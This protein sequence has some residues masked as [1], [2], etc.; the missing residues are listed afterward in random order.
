MAKKYTKAEW[1]KTNGFNAAG[2]T[3]L[4]IGYSYSIRDELKKAGF[5]FSPLLR[6]HCG[7]DRLAL[8]KSCSY[9]ELHFD[10]YFIWDEN[11]GASFMREGARDKIE[12]IF[13]PVVETRSQYVGEIGD[14]LRLVPMRTS[15]I[16]GYECEY[17]YKW[18]YTFEDDNGNF[19]SWSTTSQHP[20]SV[21]MNCFVTGT[22]KDHLNYKNIPTT[23]L[24]RCHIKV[25]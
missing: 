23:Q 14:R 21:G 9:H 18:I 1:L 25:E 5:K 12:T 20:L 6:W 2:S 15:S 4:V 10:D 22:I 7:S 24:I 16:A 3:Y 13:N 17:G 19:Y 11:A 8:P